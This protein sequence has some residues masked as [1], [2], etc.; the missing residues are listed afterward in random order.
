[1]TKRCRHCGVVFAWTRQRRERFY[2]SRNCK[3]LASYY[4]KKKQLRAWRAQQR[5]LYESAGLPVP[6]RLR[7]VLAR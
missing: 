4:R 1:M 3:C 6:E 5:K 7:E 2:C